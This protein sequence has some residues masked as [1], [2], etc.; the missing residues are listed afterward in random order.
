MDGS[1]YF[2]LAWLFFEILQVP[3]HYQSN[4][5]KYPQNKKISRTLS[6]SRCCNS[7]TVPL[8]NRWFSHSGLMSTFV[9]ASKQLDN[10]AKEVIAIFWPTHTHKF[11]KPFAWYLLFCCTKPTSLARYCKVYGDK[12]IRISW[13][14]SSNSSYRETDVKKPS[15]PMILQKK[16]LFLYL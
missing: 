9:D 5:S 2:F 10:W 15:F 12:K 14:I 16:F 11:T 8:L 7:G 1:F 3:N 6:K 4:K 13:A